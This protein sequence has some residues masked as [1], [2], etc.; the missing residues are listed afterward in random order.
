M[1]WWKILS[2]AAVFSLA[3]SAAF[4]APSV[5]LSRDTFDIAE[6]VND[7][8]LAQVKADVDKV[9]QAKLGFK[10]SKIK[11]EDLARLCEAYPNIVNLQISGDGVTSLAPV[12][13]LKGLQGLNLSGTMV[14]D[15]LP[16]AGLTEMRSLDL[17]AKFTTPDLKWMSGMTK[18]TKVS[19]KG[20][21]SRLLTSL[22]GIPPL[23]GLKE[24]YLQNAAPVDLSPMV[25]SLPALE[26]LTLFWCTLQDLTPLTKLEN[27]NDL[28]LYGSTVKDFSPLAG[29]PKLAKLMYYATKDSDYSTLG[30]LTQ[31]RE[32]KGGLTELNDISW[33]ENL[34]NLRKFDVFSEKI[35]DYSPLAKARVEDF[36]IWNMSAPADL[37]TLSGAV[38]LKKLRLL[39]C[40]RLSGFEGLGSLVNLED[41]TLQGMNAKDGSPVDMAFAKS[42]VNLK[43][44]EITSSE[45]SNFDAVAGCAK[46]E[47]VSIDAKTTGITS[48]AALK[49]LPNL[50]RVTVSKGLFPD[51]ELAGFDAKVK[52]NQR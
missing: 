29:C 11:D 4:A 32:L 39:S 47:D 49:K 37:K 44:L 19:I 26:K 3:T 14:V 36:Q 5:K 7:E 12:A 16:L 1:K 24:F 25:N 9:D 10:L 27:L 20:G 28:N 17:S 42:L 22:E 23:P 30:K 34:P 2:A 43:N 41:L 31:V 35:T 8:I 46:L 48:L 21:D 15:L 33:V 38:S 51:A 50:R 52:I 13:G 18:L 40:K 45:I 6:A